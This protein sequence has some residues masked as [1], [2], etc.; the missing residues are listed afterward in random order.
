MLS[1]VG[2]AYL[3]EE[4]SESEHQYI[5]TKDVIYFDQR[6]GVA[7][8][9]PWS[10]SLFVCETRQDKGITLQKVIQLGLTE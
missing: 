1:K 5:H 10:K 7:H 9:K 8:S 6:L 4:Q 2:S 3:F